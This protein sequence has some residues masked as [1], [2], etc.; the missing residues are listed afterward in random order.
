M[1]GQTL[2]ES[3]GCCKYFHA[4]SQLAPEGFGQECG[5]E[6]HQL[7]L[8]LPLQSGDIAVLKAGPKFEVLAVNSLKERSNST[9]AVSNGELFFRTEQTLWCITK[10]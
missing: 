7:R 2:S 8:Y 1:P 5:R 10:P 6:R 9:L 4:Q 3:T